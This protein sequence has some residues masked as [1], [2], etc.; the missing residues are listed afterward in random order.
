DEPADDP[1]ITVVGGTTLN[2]SSPG[3]PWSSETV[4]LTPASNDGQ[5]DITPQE[6]SG[7]GV[8][9][10]Y[11]IPVWQQGI[12]MTANKGSTTMRNLPDVALVAN[13]ID[14]VWGNDFIVASSDFPEG[15]TS[16]ATPLWAGFMA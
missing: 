4:W 8:S 1:Y 11:T 3:G 15:G 16:L 13:N 14:L 5:G 9:L 12:S 7:G 10:T 2:T 6:S